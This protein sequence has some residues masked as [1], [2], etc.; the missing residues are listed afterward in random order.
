MKSLVLLLFAALALV[1]FIV[2]NWSIWV[3]KYDVAYWQDVFGDSQFIRGDKARNFMSDYDSYAIIGYKLWRGDDPTSFQPDVPPLGKYLIGLSVLY[4]GNQNVG[5]LIFGGLAAL[6][7]YWLCTTLNFSLKQALS[8]QLLLWIDPLF[9]SHLTTSNLDIYLL[10]FIALALACFVR[11]L[12]QPNWFG[13][14]LFAIGL[15][16]TIKYFPPGLVLVTSM[17]TYLFILGS[18]RHFMVFFAYLPLAV[19]GFILPYGYTLAGKMSLKEFIRF[20]LWLMSWWGGSSGVKWGGILSVFMLGQWRTWWGNKATIAVPEWTPLWPTT[21]LMT[22]ITGWSRIVSRRIESV[23]II[24]IW[25]AFYLTFLIFVSSFPRY[26]LIFIPF[27]Y[28]LFINY[29]TTKDA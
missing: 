19:A 12:R 3:E 1:S 5:G 15:A 20:Q 22:L 29:F 28:I 2:G 10:V 24:W 17:L 8:V 21:L 6:T 25:C 13:A 4:F 9:R 23:S 27:V 16:T 14:T 7:I 26:L 11:G 18:F